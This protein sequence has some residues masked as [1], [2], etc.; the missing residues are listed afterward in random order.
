MNSNDITTSSTCQ[1]KTNNLSDYLVQPVLCIQTQLNRAANSH[2]V[3][4]KCNSCS[5]MMAGLL[6]RVTKATKHLLCS[7]LCRHS[8]PIKG[9]YFIFSIQYFDISILSFSS[10]IHHPVFLIH[11]TLPLPMHLC[12]P[13][14]LQYVYLL[15]CLLDI[16]VIS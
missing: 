14:V 3:A 6:P 13:S 12:F 16:N 9:K 2:A 7:V 15:F 1:L 8:F 4:K 10:H 5:Y 11:S